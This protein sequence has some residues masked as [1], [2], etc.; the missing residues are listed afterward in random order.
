M[1]AAPSNPVPVLPARYLFSFGDSYT[2]T[3]FDISG[4]QPSLSNPLGNPPYPHTTT[5]GGDNWVDI[6]VYN[7]T[8][9]DTV[10][11]N[12]A[13][14]ANFVNMTAAQGQ[15]YA[16]SGPVKELKD[17]MDQ[18]R[19]LPK[20]ILW[21]ATNSVFFNFFGVNDIAVQVFSGRSYDNA[22]KILA[23][24][25]SNYF[26]QIGQQYSLGARRF[27]VVLVPPIWRASVFDYGR[28]TTAATVRN[29][30]TIW[31]NAIQSSATSFPSRYPGAKMVIFDPTATFNQI[32]DQ[33]Q[34]YGA[35]NNTCYS[36]PA[37]QPCLWADFIH[38]GLVVQ[39]ALGNAMNTFLKSN[40][41]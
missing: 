4:A 18:F 24:D 11:Y 21:N 28:A 34:Q 22:T 6:V 19:Q 1:G 14:G 9:K 8:R 7:S 10:A 35:P 20:T 25:M 5:S 36:Y 31:N 32:L 26:T 16:P 3:G 12:Y 30:T 29:L 2:A 40:G 17:Q 41:M 15:A 37:G 38:P 27:V 33:P 13:V 23:P 39:K